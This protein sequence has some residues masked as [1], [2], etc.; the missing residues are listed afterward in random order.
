VIIKYLGVK[1]VFVEVLVI[2]FIVST[3]FVIKDYVCI[4]RQS[5]KPLP[6]LIKLTQL[7]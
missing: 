7:S 1:I 6:V 2:W 4:Y 3:F 5:L